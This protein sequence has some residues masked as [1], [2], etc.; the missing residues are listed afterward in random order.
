MNNIKVNM[1]QVRNDFSQGYNY[2]QEKNDLTDNGGMINVTCNENIQNNN[3]TLN[4]CNCDNN[5]NELSTNDVNDTKVFP[6]E[7]DLNDIDINV[8]N[9]VLE[10]DQL[11]T[12]LNQETTNQNIQQS[13]CN[14]NCESNCECMMNN[15]QDT[16]LISSIFEKHCEW[17]QSNDPT[18]Q[19]VPTTKHNCTCKVT[20]NYNPNK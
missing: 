14:C 7:T 17:T 12:N 19:Q 15:L 5:V 3:P 11:N 18:N 16:N 4:S 13:Q 1:R 9:K 8:T 20:K 6:V 2:P 10:D